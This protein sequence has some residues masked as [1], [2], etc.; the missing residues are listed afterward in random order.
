MTNNEFFTTAYAP[1]QE[2]N[3]TKG[4]ARVRLNIIENYLL[5]DHGEDSP[6]DISSSIISSIYDGMEDA[7]L[8]QNTIFGTS[9]ALRSFFKMAVE[10][11]EAFGNPVEDARKIR[12]ELGRTT[13]L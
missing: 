4:T 11:G 13:S 3:M 2:E 1:Y 5:R 12:P 10:Y 7:G 8:A 9:A 6:A